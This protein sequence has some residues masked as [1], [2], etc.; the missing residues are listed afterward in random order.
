MAGGILMPKNRGGDAYE[1]VEATALP[2]PDESKSV[3]SKG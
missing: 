2:A 3:C 1:L